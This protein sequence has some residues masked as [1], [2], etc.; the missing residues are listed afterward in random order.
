MPCYVR[1]WMIQ[2][3][4]LLLPVPGMTASAPVRLATLEWRPYVS[5]HL[6]GNGFTAEVV[7]AAAARL[8]MLVQFDYL[9]WVRAMKLGASAAQFNGYFPAYYTEERA[10]A[11]HF[12]A[13]VGTSTIG[14]AYLKAAPVVWR[15][16]NDL[17]QV[18]IGTVLGYSNGKEFD[19]LVASKAL[20]VEVSETDLQNLKKLLAQRSR[21]IVIDR[22]V[23]RY[24]LITEPSLAGARGKIEFDAKPLAELSMHVCFQRTAAGRQ[25]QTAF[26]K[27]LQHIDLQ[28]FET[29]YFDQLG[30][31]QR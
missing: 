11:C 23:L 7:S 16:L 5:S 21:A 15:T 24:L 6:A 18:K 14:L 27:A 26:D 8:D 2:L 12:S 30:A 1:R 31:A 22:L 28:Q 25:L 9:P 19:A 29:K 17:Q 20:D 4:C 3:A 10:L 13:P